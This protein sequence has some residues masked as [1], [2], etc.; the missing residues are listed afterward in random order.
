MNKKKTYIL[1]TNVLLDDAKALVSFEDND[2]ILPLI[3]IEELDRHKDR[4]DLAGMCARETTRLLNRFIQED[5]ADLRKGAPNSQGGIVKVVALS[6]I[7]QVDVAVIAS[8]HHEE[9]ADYS[10]GDNKILQLCLAINHSRDPED[11]CILITRDVLLRVKAHVLGIPAEDRKKDSIISSSNNLY[12]GCRHIAVDHNIIQMYYEYISDADSPIFSL[13]G[14]LSRIN[15]EDCDVSGKEPLRPNEFVIFIDKSTGKTVDVPLRYLG[16]DKPPRICRIPKMYK[17]K[18]KN[19]EQI[20]AL[21]LLL[22]PDIKLVTLT[23]FSG[24]GKTLLAIAAGL[25]QILDKKIYKSMLVS[26]PVQAVGK[27]IGFLPGSREEKMGPWMAPLTDNLRFLL[28]DAKD[29]GTKSKKNDMTLDHY[30]EEGIIEMEAI[31]YMRGR[32][33]ANAFMFFDEIQ[34]VS[35]HELKTIITRVGENTKIVLTGDIEQIDVLAMDSTNNGLSIAV[36]KFKDQAIAGHV[37]LTCGVR[38]ELA[39]I[40]AQVL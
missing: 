35:A 32:S 38:S 3:V 5:G 29:N 13:S 28:S 30:F 10:S 6:D 37:T 8:K 12:R 17:I 27:D 11:K 7:D 26:K 4:T 9:L 14:I 40:A 34:N 2:I 21:D 24:T 25:Q 1:D 20:M 36:E 18:P 22:D 23:G 16:E 39:T 33:I 15:E 19:L 31:T